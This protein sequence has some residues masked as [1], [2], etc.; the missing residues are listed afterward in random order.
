MQRPFVAITAALMAGIFCG[1]ICAVFVFPVRALL[2]SLLG[3]ALIIESGMLKKWKPDF[4]ATRFFFG[5]GVFLS[6]LMAAFFLAGMLL[7]DVHLRPPVPE[8]HIVH[9]ITDGKITAEGVVSENPEESPEK[10][11][12]VVSVTRIIKDKKYLPAT[13]NVLLTI[14]GENP[15]RYGDFIRFHARLKLPRNFNNPGGFDYARHLR[16]RGILARGF[17]NDATSYVILRHNQGNLLK[18]KLEEFRDL[19]R[20]TI[21]KKSPG[22]EGRI[23]QAM[24]LGNQKAIPQ[25]TMDKFSRTGLTH[26]IAISGFNI[27]IV[28][29]FALFMARLFLRAE[30]LLLRGNAAKLS[31]IL[32]IFVVIFYTGVAGAGISVLRAAIMFT[33]FLTALLMDR[34]KDLFN[35][36]AFAAFII[37]V[38]APYSLFDVSFQL[39][40]SAVAALIF[41]MPPIIRLLGPPPD[42]QAVATYQTEIKFYT[43][44]VLR[45]VVIFFF[46]SLS[47]TLGTLPLIIFYFNRI[48]LVGLAANM[49]CV[50]ILGVLAIPVSLAIVVTA[51]ISSALS[52]LVI[53]VTEVL[54]SISLFFVDR[55]AA[56][57]WASLVVATPSV[58][59]V[60]AWYLLLAWAGLALHV[61]TGEVIIKKH[62]AGRFLFFATPFAVALFF[63][64]TWSYQHIRET[65]Q[66]TLSVTTIDVGQ[67]NS[68]LVKF[69]GGKNMLVDGGG[70]FDGSFDIGKLV[71]APY[72]LHE[73]IT[74]ID[75]VALTHPDSDHLNGLLYILENFRVGEVWSNGDAAP[76]DSYRAFREII[77]KKGIPHRILPDREEEMD[78]A[79]VRI[80]IMNPV[81]SPPLK[82]TPFVQNPVDEEEKTGGTNDRALTM[83]L[84][85]GKRSFLLPSDIS[86]IVESRLADSGMDLRS[87]VLIVPH[88]GSR[89]SSSQAF[90]EK[91]AP[92]VAIVSCGYKN[93]F[94]FPHREILHRYRLMNI[95][96]YRTDLDGA[97][98]ATTDGR[99]ITVESLCF[100][101]REKAR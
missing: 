84:S 46:A 42:R 73:G 93:V 5:R 63:T 75:V 25:E 50:P 79:G 17:L 43:N 2:F 9:F 85:L 94:K 82:K 74:Q 61:L 34:E 60:A 58:W 77:R 44:T 98:Y 92:R 100:G 51:P 91:V 52:D 3:A 86:Q 53:R 80:Q 12:L 11:D 27:G 37:L 54:V 78:I 18:A 29:A 62:A 23:I 70:F 47:A 68:L 8:S 55:F 59:E 13:G 67:G 14:R 69:P 7:I 1:S 48:P 96:L 35:I 31:A 90:L 21:E 39:S 20:R 97:V 101:S 40:F 33:V 95:D 28:A 64:A 56:L 19:I 4:P 15:F 24:I 87:D 49:I 88:H 26:I 30:Y 76:S 65:R 36:L 72:L 41:F 83:K 22:T 66:E 32:A 99:N 6:F 81:H 71:V 16:L 10:T 38:I 45:G 89:F 57:P